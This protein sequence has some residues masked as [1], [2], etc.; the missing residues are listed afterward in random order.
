M[1]IRVH[2]WQGMQ[3]KGIWTQNCEIEDRLTTWRQFPFSK[4]A[5][6]V[7]IRGHKTVVQALSSS[8]GD[9]KSWSNSNGC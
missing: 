7:A 1:G 5:T 9:T 2:G 4:H 6:L 3:D 8:V